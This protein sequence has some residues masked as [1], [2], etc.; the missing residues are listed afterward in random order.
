MDKKQQLLAHCNGD[1]AAEQYISQ[2]E[3]ELE[4]RGEK[5]S[6]RAVMVHAQLVR[7]DQLGRMKAI[8]MIP[9]FF[10]AHTYYW[11]DIHIKNFGAQ[12]G[13]QIS[14]VKDALEDGMK[15]TF[16][17]DTPV[18]PPDMMRTVSCAVNRVSRTGQV[19]GENSENSGA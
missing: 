11:G 19:I 5:D 1:A 13:S 9:S 18:V 14:P 6:N 12:R 8:G 16:H 15:F 4:A 17:Q 10:V 7:K 3:K 2:F